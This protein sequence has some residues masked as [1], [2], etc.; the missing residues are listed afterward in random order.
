MCHKIILGQKREKKTQTS[1]AVG[2]VPDLASRIVPF[3]STILRNT[4]SASNFSWLSEN[5]KDFFVRLSYNGE[6]RNCN[7]ATRIFFRNSQLACPH[8]K[9]HYAGTVRRN[10]MKKSNK[11]CNKNLFLRKKTFQLNFQLLYRRYLSSRTEHWS[12]WAQI[13]LSVFP[14]TVKSNILAE[15]GRKKRLSQC[16][17]VRKCK[18][19]TKLRRKSFEMTRNSWYCVTR[20]GHR[21]GNCSLPS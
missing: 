21:L 12:F 1:Q 6:N 17:T 10:L 8:S 14:T 2:K 9:R 20:I 19:F 15:S 4:R 18:N 11:T 16:S 13:S 7:P 5:V 3:S